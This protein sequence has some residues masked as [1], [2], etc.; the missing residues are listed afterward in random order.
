MYGLIALGFHVTYVVSNTVNFAQGSLDDAG[1]RARLHLRGHARAGRC[2][3]RPWPGARALRA[4]RRRGR[5]H[6]GAAVRRARLERLADGDGRGRHRARQR[7]CC[8]PSARSRAAFR[9]VLATKPMEIFGAGVYPLQ[10]VI[11]VVGSRCGRCC[12]SCSHRTRLGKALLAVVQNP[13][14]ARLMG[15]N[16]RRAI[17]VSFMLSTA[18]AGL[19]GP[20]DRAAVQRA[21][22]HGHAVRHQGVRGRDPRRH[23]LGLGRDAG[24]PDLRR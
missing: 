4:V 16:V 10:L 7:W 8:S 6:A 18:L 12:T 11:P 17:A 22:R 15:I 14:A 19:A 1:R 20:L 3:W 24:R 2:R 23:H 21:F 5:A 9:S 13:D